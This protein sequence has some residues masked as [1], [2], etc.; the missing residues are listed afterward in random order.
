M[1]SKTIHLIIGPLL[2][3]VISNL[4][5]PDLSV[6]GQAV[7]ACTIWVAYWWITEALELAVTALLPVIIFPLTGAAN[8]ESVTSSYGHPFIFLFMGGFILGL[9]IEHTGLH[10]RI[11]YKIIEWLGTSPKRVILGFLIA[12][13]FLSMWLSNTA[14]A[15]MI[16]PIGISIS[17]HFSSQ[18]EFSKNLMLA[19]AYGASIGGLATLIGSPPNIIFAGIIQQNLG[20]EITFL[21]WMT[22]A[23]P[24]TI[25]LLIVAWFYL[26]RF[27]VNKS[28]TENK[29]FNFSDL[30]KMTTAE[31]RVLI[32]FAT[33]A[34]LW[35][36]KDFLLKKHFPQLDDTII[37]IAGAISLFIITGDP[38]SKQK[39]MTWRVAREMPWGVLL[40]FGAGLAIANGFSSTDLTI[41]LG[42]LLS[43][44]N[45]LPVS[46]FLLI[47]IAS[48]NFL[49]EITS[50]TATASMMLPVLIALGSNHGMN[51]IGL[52]A[53]ATIACSCAFMLPV[54]TPPNAIV[55][56]SEKI[57]LKQMINA[58]LYMNI[59]SI[60]IIYLGVQL[61]GHFLV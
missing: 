21:K 19:I 56:G 32:V 48:I 30:P 16:L 24:I 37:A 46:I 26:T 57:S 4:D 58:G 31:K 9:A 38:K 15:I 7:L 47:V 33:V 40:L 44:A 42:Q 55:F 14:T 60:I 22:F 59:I 28:I 49:T 50:N 10:K 2:Y 35:I 43:I 23:L 51:L 45:L 1:K 61:L 25:A 5:L 39:I 27:K 34:T 41:W 11:A 18:K 20:I 36:T 6:E 13:A 54:A 12:T 3:F 17:N 29:A 53:G 52:L 8:I